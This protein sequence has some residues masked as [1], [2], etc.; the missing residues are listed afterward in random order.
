LAFQILI[1]TMHITDPEIRGD[2][3]T[4]ALTARSAHT[5]GPSQGILTQDRDSTPPADGTET[6]TVTGVNTEAESPASL[7]TAEAF[8]KRSDLG[9]NIRKKAITQF[10]IARDL[11]EKC[12]ILNSQADGDIKAHDAARS[13]MNSLSGLIDDYDIFDLK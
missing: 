5:A 10:K 4:E 3:T 12:L 1:S 2:M 9:L 13:R 7:I 11:V 6:I 8:E